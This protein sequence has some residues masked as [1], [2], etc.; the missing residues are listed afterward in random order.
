MR[1]AA[2]VGVLWH[3]FLHVYPGIIKENEETFS[4]DRA[5]A[6][7]QVVTHPHADVLAQLGSYFAP[8][9][10]AIFLFISG[11]G[12]VCSYEGDNPKHQGESAFKFCLRHY[13]KLLKLLLPVLLL[14]AVL[15]QLGSPLA[16][17]F[18][19]RRFVLQA[20]MV[21]NLMPNEATLFIHGPWWF[22]G[23]ILQL[24]IIYRLIIYAPP[25]ANG[26]RRYG[27]PIAITLACWALMRF[28]DPAGHLQQWLHHNAVAHIATFAVG[29]VTARCV[30]DVRSGVTSKGR[31]AIITLL[32][33]QQPKP[34]GWAVVGWLAV[35][36]GMAVV[37]V[38]ASLRFATWLWAPLFALTCAIA[39]VRLCPTRL[40]QPLA[41]LGKLSAAIYV[42]H[43]L[44]RKALL[45]R[46]GN[47]WLALAVF[48]LTTLLAAI[49][50]QWLIGKA[51]QALNRLKK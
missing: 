41:W 8:F 34:H 42:I 1:G 46:L 6:M 9:C 27:I 35:A 21:T 29:I 19:W 14:V 51:E 17:R 11:Y 18:T 26:W 5:Q 38:V 24:Y 15:N 40:L 32:D 13:L 4:P 30:T 7:L 28:I 48:M 12:L 16:F 45:F 22:M 25:T 2:I 49:V 3:N 20:L 43:P 37:A 31:R 44:L 10:L 50:Y 36:A 33:T 39:L 23:M 47:M